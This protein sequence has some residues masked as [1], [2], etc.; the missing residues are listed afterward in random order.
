MLPN[1]Q[2]QVRVRSNFAGEVEVLVR[3]GERV[4]AG[5]G[6]LIVEGE[7]ELERLAARN[8]GTVTEVNV[9]SGAE[10]EK[11]ALLVVIQEDAPST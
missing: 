6:L 10:V 11:G 9:R 3:I 2:N 7:G 4:H 8:P 5:Q 1:R